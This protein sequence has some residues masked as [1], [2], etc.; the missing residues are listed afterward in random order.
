VSNEHQE[1]GVKARHSWQLRAWTTQISM[2]RAIKKPQ[3]VAFRGIKPK[4]LYL[5]VKKMA[6][7]QLFQGCW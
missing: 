5:L 2:F 6:T 3:F 4:V 1:Q 7:I